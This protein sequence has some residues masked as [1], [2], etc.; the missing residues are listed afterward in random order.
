MCTKYDIEWLGVPAYSKSLDEK[1]WKDNSQR[2]FKKRPKKKKR[3]AS[4]W[5]CSAPYT[6]FSVMLKI[7]SGK[8]GIT[9]K[10]SYIVTNLICMSC[11]S[12]RKKLPQFLPQC[13]LLSKTNLII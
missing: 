3:T 4:R 5:Q 9:V 2:K 13:F 12:V 1:G 8:R 10:S 11:T 7:V 6:C